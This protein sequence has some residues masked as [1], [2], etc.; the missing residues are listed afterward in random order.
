MMTDMDE[1]DIHSS[2]DCVTEEIEMAYWTRQVDGKYVDLMDCKWFRDWYRLD[3]YEGDDEYFLPVA[4]VTIDM[5][6]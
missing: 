6:S 4:N 1:P 5:I 2:R 3:M